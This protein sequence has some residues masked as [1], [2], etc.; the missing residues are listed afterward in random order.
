MQLDRLC[1][2]LRR[3]SPWEAVDLG[4]PL[5]R[6]WAK[7]VYAA[8]F[9][10]CVPLMLLFFVAFWNYPGIGVI[11]AWWLKPLF[12]R[13]LLQVYA[14]ALFAEPPRPA[15]LWRSLPRLIR[16]TGLLRA[17]TLGRLSVQ[18]SFHLPIVLLE[19]QRGKDY[20]ERR[21]IL[22]RG[23]SGCAMW[24]TFVCANVSGLLQL[25]LIVLIELFRPEDAGSLIDWGELLKDEEAPPLTGFVINLLWLTAETLVEPFYVVAGF[26]LYLNRRND[27]EGWDIELGF[28]QLAERLASRS[29]LAVSGLLLALGLSLGVGLAT[30]PLPSDAKAIKAELAESP[31]K[32]TIRDVLADK[33]FGYE[34]QEDSW[35]YRYPDK[36]DPAKKDAEPWTD[37]AWLRDLLTLLA[38]ALR[39]LS[40]VVAAMVIAGL[41]YLLY[42]QRHRWWLAAGPPNPPPTWRR[43]LWFAPE[44][45]P[46]DPAGVALRLAEQG[47]ARAALS[48][49]YRASLAALANG[50]AVE[51]AAGD[52][53]SDCLRRLRGRIEPER[54]RYLRGVV[55]AWNATAYAAA[56]PSAERVVGLCRAWPEC[57]AE[58]TETTP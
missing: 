31:A 3:R 28:R 47:Q 50:G 53:E 52:T 43:G 35:K 8:W 20:G 55:D 41:L 4:L 42:R 38:E 30:W 51:F 48:L 11:A 12:D 22:N 58:P 56:P 57:F 13:V 46:D 39:N 14:G 36:D 10:V 54:E 25:S 33:D 32:K 29:S 49:L 40:Y 19:G 6:R 45:L 9:G 21:A 26:T 24:L 23:A 2:A 1:V 15:A 34:T 16:R 27:L 17:V 7:P 18:R 37:M 5:L 44:T